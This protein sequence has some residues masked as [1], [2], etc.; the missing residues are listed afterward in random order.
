[1]IDVLYHY[2]SQKEYLLHEFVVMPRHI[3]VIISPHQTVERAVQLIKG[4]FA[5]RAKRNFGWRETVWQ[6][7]FNDRRLRDVNEYVATREYLLDNP[8]K[9]GYCA[10]RAQW[11]YS[12]ATS[13]FELDEIPQRLKPSGVNAGSHA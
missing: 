11:P 5:F 7:S 9:A 13:K 8:V 6:K 10:Q 2:R 4:G 3:H 12:S 1:M